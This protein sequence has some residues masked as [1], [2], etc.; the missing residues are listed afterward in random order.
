M[1]RKEEIRIL[2]VAI[3]NGTQP[4]R[5]ASGRTILK[6]GESAKSYLVLANGDQLTRAGEYW[7]QKTKQNKPERHFDPN[8]ETVRKGD[9]D[10][11]NTS[12]GLKRVRHL[13]PDGTMKVTALG[14]RFYTN[15]H[16]EYI[17]E[18]PVIIRVR[19]SKGRKRERRGEHLP[20]NQSG[21]STV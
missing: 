17:V 2:D 18:A 15:K 13:Q 12:S 10:Y 9:G 4:R 5:V 7:Y 14:K 3:A 21:L 11:I 16:T 20:V 8:Q 19:D 1:N 6:T